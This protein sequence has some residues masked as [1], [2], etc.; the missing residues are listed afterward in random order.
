MPPA[1][2]R[3][4]ETGKD[5]ARLRNCSGFYSEAIALDFAASGPGMG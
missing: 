3:G 2:W 1:S 4:A 5:T